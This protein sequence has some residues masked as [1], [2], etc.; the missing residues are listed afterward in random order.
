MSKYLSNLCLQSC[1]LSL[2]A[3]GLLVQPIAAKQKASGK[4]VEKSTQAP[5]SEPNKVDANG[6]K[7]LPLNM[8]LPKPVFDGTPEDARISRLE[9]PHGLRPPFYAPEGTTNVASG[10]SVV[11]NQEPIIGDLTMIT[12]GDKEAADGSFVEFGPGIN[13]ITIDLGAEYNIY[14]IVVWHYHKQQQVYFDV[15]VQTSD[16]SNFISNVKT[17]FNNDRDNS[18]GQGIGQNLHYVDTYEGRLIDAKC[19]KGR[20]VRLYS[21]G[22]SSNEQNHYTEVEVYGKAAK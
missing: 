15:I 3:L 22:N 21:N 8:K 10:K 5:K 2:I 16:D 18:A 19:V 11:C 20:Y 6:V 7:M 4:P 9:K 1:I 17:L 13:H 14:A 12:D